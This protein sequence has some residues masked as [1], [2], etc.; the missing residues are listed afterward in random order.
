MCF[1]ILFEMK[2]FM[3]PVLVFAS[4]LLSCS[5]VQKNSEK[6]K[7]VCVKLLQFQKDSLV[8]SFEK[9]F[10][11]DSTAIEVRKIPI[12]DT[13]ALCAYGIV[14]GDVDLVEKSVDAAT[15]NLKMTFRVQLMYHYPNNDV[16]EIK[17]LQFD[18][19]R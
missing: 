2:K 1:L 12:L 5:S 9:F 19:T 18:I 16:T 3:L 13:L 8:I 11:Q 10:A 7:N 14:A 17:K 4:L 15:D 6:P